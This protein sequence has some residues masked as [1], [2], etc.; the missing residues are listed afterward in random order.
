[1]ELYHNC[2]D[3]ANAFGAVALAVYVSTRQLDATNCFG[4]V[5][6]DVPSSY[7]RFGVDAAL[8]ETKGTNPIEFNN[9]LVST[10]LISPPCE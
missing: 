3:V 9:P 2:L 7:A 8:V 10:N 4:L 6:T 1:M 5:A